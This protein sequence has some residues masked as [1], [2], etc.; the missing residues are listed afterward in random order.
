MG[1]VSPL[2]TPAP[3]NSTVITQELSWGQCYWSCQGPRIPRWLST[4]PGQLLIQGGLSRQAMEQEINAINAKAVGYVNQLHDNS[5]YLGY[6]SVVLIIAG[7]MATFIISTTSDFG[8]SP[9]FGFIGLWVGI[10]IALIINYCVQNRHKTIWNECLNHVTSYINSE[11]NSRYQSIGFVWSIRSRSVMH[12]GGKNRYYMTYN[13]ICVS[14][15]TQQQ[16]IIQQQQ[17]AVIYVDQNGNRIQPQ[18]QVIVVNQNGV[19]IQN[20]VQMQPQ[21]GES[22]PLQPQVASA[23]PAYE[24]QAPPAYAPQDGRVTNM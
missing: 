9:S 17:P 5:H 16:V 19:P 10:I 11:V 24:A 18:Q 20:Q 6:F 13:D 8:F 21:T 7:A 14:P 4:P 2:F 3:V 1:N 12:G 23:P 22:A 15:P